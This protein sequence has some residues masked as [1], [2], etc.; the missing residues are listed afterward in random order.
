LPRIVALLDEN[1][2]AISHLKLRQFDATS[3]LTRQAFQRL[4]LTL[5]PRPVP[6]QGFS[7]RRRGLARRFPEG[8]DWPAAFQRP[9]PIGRPNDAQKASA[10][11]DVECCINKAPCS[12]STII[13]TT[14]RLRLSKLPRSPISAS[15]RL[16]N[17]SKDLTASYQGGWY[18]LISLHGGGSPEAMKRE[19]WRNYPVMDNVELV[20]RLL[21][22]GVVDQGQRVSRQPGRCCATGCQ[23]PA[24]P[25]TAN[26]AIAAE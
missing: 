24:P 18:S 26:A 6:N 4:R 7:S 1:D 19:I 17:A 14:E 12:A 20:E 2:N 21:D 5:F 16:V 8:R 13:S 22:R 15:R 9:S 3:L 11:A 10:T 23:V 25:G